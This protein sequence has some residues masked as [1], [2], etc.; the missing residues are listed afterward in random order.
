MLRRCLLPS[1]TGFPRILH[2]VSRPHKESFQAG[3]EPRSRKIGRIFEG[4]HKH[5]GGLGKVFVRADFRGGDEDS[6]FSVFRVRRFSE[7]PEPLH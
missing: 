2:L 3:P 5:A 4:Y 6:N 1:P 7:W